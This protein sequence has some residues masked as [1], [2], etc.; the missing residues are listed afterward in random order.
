MIGRNWVW[1]RFFSRHLV[2]WILF[3][4]GP[5]LAAGW[6]QGS[7]ISTSI[8][9]QNIQKISLYWHFHT[10]KIYLNTNIGP[11]LSRQASQLHVETYS[12]YCVFI[13]SINVKIKE[14]FWQSPYNANRDEFEALVGPG[15]DDFEIWKGVKSIAT[16]LSQVHNRKI[17]SFI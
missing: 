17:Y 12:K 3:K 8:R 13:T 15:R 11:D 4:S 7:S 5:L 2:A 16:K 9:I 1:E 6:Q 14:L 10:L